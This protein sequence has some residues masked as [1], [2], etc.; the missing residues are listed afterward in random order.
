M[1]EYIFFCV[2]IASLVISILLLS[3]FVAFWW[4][5][6]M[7]LTTPVWFYLGLTLGNRLDAHITT[8]KTTELEQ[9][10]ER[11]SEEQKVLREQS[12]KDEKEFDEQ[13]RVHS[14]AWKKDLESPGPKQD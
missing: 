2:G 5:L 14:E 6:L 9:K 4:S 8:K 13:Q 10:L 1:N 12:E 3:R 7:L 11:L